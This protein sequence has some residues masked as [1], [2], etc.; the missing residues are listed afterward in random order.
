MRR[1]KE[2]LF[3]SNVSSLVIDEF[4]TLLDSG[5]EDKIKMLMD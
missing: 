1:D 4:D 3:L 5:N 2:K